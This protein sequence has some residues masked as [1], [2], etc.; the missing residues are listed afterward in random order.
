MFRPTKVKHYIR[1][2]EARGYTVEQVLNG[3]R[4][5]AEL[6]DDNTYLIDVS[7][8]HR[9]VSNMLELTGNPN[10]GLD[11]GREVT[12]DDFGIIGYALMCARD[13][14][15]VTEIWLTMGH[16][17][18]GALF[19]LELVENYQ[20][21]YR[22]EFHEIF[23]L[24]NLLRFCAEENLTFGNWIGSNVTGQNLIY[25]SVELA[26]PE[27]ENSVIYKEVFKTD[28]VFD[29][30]VTAVNIR[31]PELSFPSPK[32]RDKEFYQLCRDYCFQLMRQISEGKP[33]SFKIRQVFLD[34]GGNLPSI[35]YVADYLCLSVRT[36]KRHLNSEGVTF[37]KLSAEF[38]NDLAKEYLKKSQ[39]MPL[40]KLADLLGYK[41]AKSFSRAFINWNGMSVSEYRKLQH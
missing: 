24:G 6:L 33:L 9:V 17:L 20:Q 2:M 13:L 35:E 3:S 38:R 7:Q 32:R 11:M 40:Q 1:R 41:D 22:V 4:I 5:E 28:I 34:S 19:R 18:V 14:R 23:P 16:P 39:S 12:F 26:Y 25:N 8:A 36:L 15:D 37:Q 10:L 21:G 29:A 31:S 27:P 30:P